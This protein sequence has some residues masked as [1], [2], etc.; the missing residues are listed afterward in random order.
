MRTEL[1]DDGVAI[2]WAIF[3]REFLRKYFPED[4][5][6]RKEIEFLELKQDNMTVSEYASKFVELEK[7]YVHYNNDAAGEFS[8]R[9]FEEDN[10]K[11]KSAH[12]RELV[13]KRGKKLMDRGKPYGKGNPKAGDWKKPSGGDSSALIRCYNCGY[14]ATDCR[15]AIMTCYNYSKEG[16]ISP[17]CTKPKKNQSGGKI[18]ALSGL[19]TTSEDRLIKDASVEDLAMIA[20][21][22]DEAI[23]D[24]AVVFMLI[25][26]MELKG[27]A[28][29]SALLVSQLRKYI[30][31]P[32]HVIQVD[33]VQVKDNLTV[34]AFPMRIKDWKLK[35][36]RGKE[37]SLMR[38]AWGGTTGW[39][40]HG[41]WR[42]K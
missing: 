16:H 17:Q 22:V 13:E 23:K 41:R 12:S 40:L 39:M 26:S 19:E 36:L 4:V 20:R 1:D 24:G 34:E 25:A 33:G 38:V 42:F 11:V 14:I 29:G 2:I 27:K 18:F 3:K 37:I 35:Q 9:I 8:N 21:Q 7:F 5:W 28:V 6:G 31:D 10:I 30:A 32:S 15:M